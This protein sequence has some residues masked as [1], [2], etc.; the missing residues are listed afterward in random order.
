MAG[1]LTA[2]RLEILS[3]DISTTQD[4]AV[5]DSFRVHDRDYSGVSPQERIAA[6]STALRDVLR[7]RVTVE[8]LFVRHRRFGAQDQPPPVSNLPMRVV[9]DN[10]SSDSRTVVD[11]FA[12]DRPGLLYT[13]ARALY[14]L[15]LSVDLARISTHYDQVVDVFYVRETNGRKAAG[16]ARLAE[17]QETL[18]ARLEAFERSEF[19]TFVA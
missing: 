16:D 7:N 15:R 3:A 1:V 12:H 5:V 13:V 11:V 8:S 10:D 6:V 9:L 19:R 17:I 2:K 18:T 14:E 4:G